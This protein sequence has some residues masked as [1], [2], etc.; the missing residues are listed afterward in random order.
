MTA[1][2]RNVLCARVAVL[3]PCHN[4]QETVAE[5]VA[6]FS[7]ALPEADVYVYDNRST[8]AT[9]E[10]ARQAG[11]VVRREVRLGKGHVVRRMFADVEAE[12]YVMVDGDGT[13]EA[14]AARAMVD[15]LIDD[16]LDMVVGCRQPVPDQH[17]VY[18][19]GH[20]MGNKVFTR[21][22]R[23]VFGGEFTDVFSGYRVMSRRLV[24]SFPIQ[25]AG[26]EIE[27]ELNVH[28]VQLGAA[29][30]EVPTRYGNRDEDSDSKLRTGRDGIRIMMTILRLFRQLRPLQFFGILFVALTLVALALGIPVVEA[31]VDTGLVARFPTAIMAAAIQTVAFICLTCGLVLENVVGARKEARRLAYLQI[32]RVARPPRGTTFGP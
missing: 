10:R 16:T 15:L 30:A 22:L 27:T 9:A 31:Y 11:A 26:F 1:G 20:A 5:V 32:P 28:A 29:C 25:S 24:K 14:A 8:D 12:I 17:D 4:E 2:D 13:Y 23:T 18:R 19:P 6:A 21:A 7:Q 3:I